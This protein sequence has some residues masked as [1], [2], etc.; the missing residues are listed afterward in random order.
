MTACLVTGGAGFLGSH[1]VN[2]LAEHGD[3]VR[4][5]DN[6]SSGKEGNLS[7]LVEPVEV[8]AGD[9]NN[10]ALVRQATEGVDVVYHLAPPCGWR[11]KAE[12]EHGSADVGIMHVLIAARDSQVR[13]VV[14]ASSLCVYGEAT[15]GLRGEGDPKRP[16]SA[17]AQAK[18]TGELD[19][20]TFTHQYGLETVCLR[21]ANLYGPRQTSLLGYAE[22]VPR[23]LRALLAGQRPPLKGDGLT[24]VDLLFVEDAVAATLLAAQRE[25]LSARVYNVGSGRPTTQLEVLACLNG[26]LGTRLA[27]LPGAARPPGELENLLDGARAQHELGFLPRTDLHSGLALCVVEH[28]PG[29]MQSRN[30][31]GPGVRAGS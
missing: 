26:L 5:L 24:P 25:Q 15:A 20:T 29:G 2:A 1:L 13:R 22:L 31:L 30:G 10:L 18:L 16:H 12:A 11:D 17:Y 19:C 6:F 9:L 14:Y 27:P 8:I 28:A 3:R 7:L 23:A 21:Y 4:V